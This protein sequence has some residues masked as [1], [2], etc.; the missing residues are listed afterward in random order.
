MNTRKA[1]NGRSVVLGLAGVCLICGLT[2]FN[3]YV[4]RNT[5]FVGNH[6]PASLLIFFL[7]FV[8]LLN[9]ALHRWRPRAALGGH[10][11]AVALGM[12][13][14]GCALPSVGLMRYLPGHLVAP[15]G[16]AAIDRPTADLLN[17]LDL[18]DWMWPT[19][20]SDD[21]AERGRDPVVSNFF[22]P[23]RIEKDTFLNRV[24]AVPWSAW[25]QPAVSW[26][27]FFAALFGAV[28]C[29][30]AI[31]RRQWVENERLPFPLATVYLSLIEPPPKGRALNDLLRSRLFWCAFAAVFSIHALG[32]LHVYW[33]QYWPDMPLRFDLTAILAERPFNAA[34]QEFKSQQVYFTIIGLMFFIQA[35]VAFSLWFFFIVLQVTQMMYG[36]YYHA[37]FTRPM[38]SDQLFG[39]MMIMG[40]LTLWVGRQQLGLVA[41]QM[42]RRARA[43]EAV[44]RYLPYTMAGWGLVGCC[45]TLVVWLTWAGASVA[46]AM[47]LV[48]VILLVYL[49]VARVVAETG[50][51]YV[52][53]PVSPDRFWLT[54][55]D[56]TGA[57]TTLGSTY[58]SNMFFG[59]L[60]HDTR[61]TSSVY[62]IHAMRVADERAYQGERNWHRAI[63]FTFCLVLALAV[64]FAVSGASTLYVHYNYATSLDQVQ[65]SP[66][67]SW[68]AWTMPKVIGLDS[69]QS[70]IPPRM[71]AAD[72][73]WRLGH[74]GFGA[75]LAGMLGVLNLRFAA[76]P[77]HPV[78]YLLC[79]TW[80]IGQIW[81]SIFLG[82]LCKMLIVRYGGLEVL[83]WIRPLFLGLIFG[84]AAAI[85]L[86]L[87]VSLILNTLG[88]PY[89]AILV[90]PI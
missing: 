71:G 69:T 63:G 54:F 85:V 81:F 52:L 49:V 90:L 38:A 35:R 72:S 25:A 58:L 48:G 68:G 45:A 39:A 57:R 23:V 41:R 88:E 27:V 61:E 65:E 62:M 51:L 1:V 60:L 47:V 7:L 89:H 75:L 5:D 17:L 46:G 70:Y 76:W 28:V 36:T 22:W 44:G 53:L 26:G 78:G 13:L 12:A 6:L 79:T 66:I 24:K 30:S 29:L 56:L 8:L 20:E 15:F 50:L 83:R 14:V 42:V 77:L 4:L 10:E 2:P 67:G 74:L 18:P 73:H 31:F 32:A 9:A 80:G 59:M 64:A 82:W 43:G 84:E 55:S 34:Q 19:M 40:A 86:W 21:P 16:H 3:N 33:P 37:E 11:L 87:T